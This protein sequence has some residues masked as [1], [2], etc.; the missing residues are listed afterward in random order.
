MRE[1]VFVSLIPLALSLVLVSTSSAQTQPG[2]STGGALLYETYCIGCHTTQ[3]HWRDKKLAVDWSSLWHQ[4]SRW[5]A[6][7]ALQWT[8]DQIDEVARYLND[9]IYHFPE[10]H[11]RAAATVK[12]A[13]D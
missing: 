1:R 10:P 11:R 9:A 7:T 2:S 3:I 4:V 5:Q 12:R 13:V 6:N 8:D